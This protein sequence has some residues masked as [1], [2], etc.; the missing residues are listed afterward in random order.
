MYSMIIP[1]K[2]ASVLVDHIF[3]VFDGDSNGSIDFAVIHSF[4]SCRLR[5]ISYNVQEFM[6]ATDMTSCGS[7]EEKLRWA[8]K[9]YDEDGSGKY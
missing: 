2:N 3:N 8:F 7:T 6:I 1:E 4:K 5:V 9:M